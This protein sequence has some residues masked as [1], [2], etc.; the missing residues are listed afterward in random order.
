MG[1][2]ERIPDWLILT[3]ACLLTAESPEESLLRVHHPSCHSLE[4]EPGDL[5]GA[6]AMLLEFSTTNT[7]N[8][9]NPFFSAITQPQ[10]F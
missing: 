8:E 7:V 5:T 4:P 9:I 6:Y 10:T 1:P 2:S 3:L